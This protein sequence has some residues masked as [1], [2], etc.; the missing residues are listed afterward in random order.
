[1]QLRS[2]TDS[3]NQVRSRYAI[4]CVFTRSEDNI[5]LIVGYVVYVF[6]ADLIEWRGMVD[7]LGYL[8]GEYSNESFCRDAWARKRESK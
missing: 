1:M 2:V 4:R 3:Y 8:C 6:V 7:H 5:N